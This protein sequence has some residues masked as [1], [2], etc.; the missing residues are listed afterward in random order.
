MAI[1][2]REGVIPTHVANA[3]SRSLDAEIAQ[4]RELGALAAEHELSSL[5]L[6]DT[7]ETREVKT[8]FERTVRTI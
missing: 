3:A 8:I 5:R 2:V 4:K 1:V 6:A 7:L